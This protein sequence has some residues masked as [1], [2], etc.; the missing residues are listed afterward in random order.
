MQIHGMYLIG[1]FSSMLLECLVANPLSK[2]DTCD[3]S[4]LCA[5]YLTVPGIQQ[6]LGHLRKQSHDT[7]MTRDSH[8]MRDSH[9]TLT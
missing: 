4:R 3:A 2:G 9:M 7:H 6:V 1:N 8:M 5:G